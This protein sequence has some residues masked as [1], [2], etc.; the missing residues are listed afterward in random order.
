[1][2]TIYILFAFCILFSCSK[3]TTMITPEK[4]LN[5]EEEKVIEGENE[6]KKRTICTF[7]LSK[8]TVNEIVTVDCMID[9]EGETINLPL[10]VNFDFKGGTLTNGTLVFSG[11][12]SKIDGELLNHTLTVEGDVSLKKDTFDFVSTQWNITEGQTT[13]EIALENTAILEN[14]FLEIKKLGGKTFRIDNL[15]AYFEVTK[16]TST[17]TNQNWYPSLEAVN[18]PSDFNLEM[19]D[20][21]HLRMFPADKFNRKNGAILAVRDAENI[22]IK[23]GKLYG[24]K[25]ERVFS[26]DDTGIEGSHLLHIHSGR[27]VIVDGLKF[28]NGSSGSL[29]I[30]SL[31]FSFNPDYKPS[32]N[33]TIKNCTIKNSRRMGLALTDG[34]DILIENNTFINTGQPT[35]KVDGGEVGYAI[36]IEPDRF[37]DTSGEIKERQKVF[38]VTIRGNTEYG[39]RVGFLTLTIG[40][41]ITVEN[42]IIG[43]KVVSSLMSGIKIKNNMFKAVGK[44]KEGWALFI[45]GTG[46]TVFDNE[47]FENS[48]EGYSLGMVIGSYDAYV[49]HN[50]IRNCNAGI[51]ISKAKK[52]RIYDNVIDVKANGIQATNTTCDDVEFVRN[53]VSTSGN[54][55]VYVANTNHKIEDRNNNIIFQMNTFHNDKTLILSNTAG[56]TFK[57]NV[58]SGGLS[59][60]NTY[61][62]E[63]SDND[64][65]PGERNGIRLYNTL[66]NI[67]VQYNIIKKP[68]GTTGDYECIKNTSAIDSKNILVINNT[69]N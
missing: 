20:N 46:E 61:N 66:N 49:H 18:I 16:V 7:D 64:I 10:N 1:M 33:I 68:T 21:T 15:D 39:S 8:L 60:N 9:L 2:K 5:K 26:P 37:R 56:V 13:S 19:T 59:I 22:T 63:V 35:A 58:I 50:T 67:D 48:I 24:D 53:T 65:T 57:E 38:N 29:A 34:R 12:K 11:N 4:E 44:A 41:D 3:D 28:E 23:G 69:C 47:V 51:Q 43:T 55:N 42:N 30:Y 14:L 6:E 31:G 54:Y 62:I 36:N 27:N 25:E 17:T 52:A 32:Q 40:Q 45:A